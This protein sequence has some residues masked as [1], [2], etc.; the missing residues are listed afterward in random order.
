MSNPV[1]KWKAGATSPA[2]QDTLLDADGNAI[3][4]TGATV[5]FVMGPVA[6]GSASVQGA[7]SIVSASSGIVSYAWGTADL[8]T[9]GLYYAY[10]QVQYSG[11]AVEKLPQGGAFAGDP[12]S[13]LIRVTPDLS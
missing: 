2:I 13:L 3:D 1:R 12:E 11:G 4:L 10:W 7:A 6:S 5:T 9:P 8:A